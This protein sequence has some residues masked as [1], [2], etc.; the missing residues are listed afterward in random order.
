MLVNSEPN[1]CTLVVIQ[2]WAGDSAAPWWLN[3]NDM[4]CW[5]ARPNLKKSGFRIYFRQCWLVLLAWECF[6]RGANVLRAWAS[7]KTVASTDVCVMGGAGEQVRDAAGTRRAGPFISNTNA[8]SCAALSFLIKLWVCTGMQGL[9]TN[10][11]QTPA[12]GW[13][14]TVVTFCLLLSWRRVISRGLLLFF[15]HA[16]FVRWPEKTS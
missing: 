15:Q 9:R 12:Q 11:K 2:M 7:D 5:A 1:Y 16:A 3:G 6:H 13:R 4:F 8:Q 14:Y 10:Q